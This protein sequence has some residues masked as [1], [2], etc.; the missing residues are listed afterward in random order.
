VFKDKIFYNNSKENNMRGNKGIKIFA[1]IIAI[2]V[3]G[4]ALGLW[5]TTDDENNIIKFIE[6]D[7][8]QHYKP[9]DYFGGLEK[10]NKVV[11]N[12]NIK[13]KWCLDNGYELLRINISKCT[14]DKS[15]INL[16]DFHLLN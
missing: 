9:V 3:I 6:L 16:Y 1:V 12:D 11:I 14:T 7:G 15:F 2:S 4:Q 8:E 5:N 13:N 10:F